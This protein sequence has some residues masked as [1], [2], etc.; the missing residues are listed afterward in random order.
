VK[1]SEPSRP[2]TVTITDAPNCFGTSSRMN[3]FPMTCSIACASFA[4]D[5]GWSELAHIACG[6]PLAGTGLTGSGTAEMRS[7]DVLIP[8]IVRNAYPPEPDAV[9]EILTALAGGP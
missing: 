7:S 3:S 4:I 8:R 9:R 5:G 6:K 1:E 2:I